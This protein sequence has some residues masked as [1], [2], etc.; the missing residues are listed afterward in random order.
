[1]DARRIATIFDL[2]GTLVQTEA[3]KALSYARAAVELSPESVRAQEIIVAY[4]DMVGHSR[5]EVAAALLERFG[6]ESHAERRMRELNA[7]TPLDAYMTLRLRIYE[8]MISDGAL[9]REQ[10]YPW[11]TS[12]LRAVRR[13][14]HRVGIATM[15]HRKH[16]SLVLER[17]GLA[18]DVD[19]LVTREDVREAKPSP[20]IYLLIAR[21][22][23]A[24][25]HEC[26]VLEDS[27]PG[28]R[29]AN[30]AGMCCVAITNDMTRDAIH[31]AAVL[32]VERVVDDPARLGAVARELLDDLARQ[33]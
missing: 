8:T 30:A 19:V 4:D 29:A 3:L 27:L 25:P 5:E 13:D 15:S 21:R 31:A 18:G 14:G 17:L 16:A 32:P 22:L 28:V 1:M 23:G 9:I 26:F 33:R 10:E 24:E 7:A 11:S 2:D 20:E 6:L 12:L